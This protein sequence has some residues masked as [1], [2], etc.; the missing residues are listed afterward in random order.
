[1]IE[2]RLYPAAALHGRVAHE[3]GRQIV[4]GAIA[5]GT[6]LPREAELA[7][8]YGVSR[9]AVREGLKVLAA[10]GLVVSRRRAGTRVTPRQAWNLLDPDVLA[11]H[12]P[13]AI[14]A[15]FLK[16]LV[17]LRRLIEPAAASLAA[18]RGDRDKIATLAAVLERMRTAVAAEDG[19]TY[20]TVDAEFHFAIFRASGNM[21]IERLSS[22][23]G[24]LYDA[25]FRVQMQSGPPFTPGLAIHVAVYDAIVAGDG[26][27]A[28]Q[29]MEHILDRASNE[30]A[31]LNRR[32]P[33]AG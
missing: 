10:K 8:R 4:S 13:D 27:R 18:E 11:W 22:I 29:A 9:Q 1:L 20:R 14:N 3:I 28:R 26:P 25:T 24:P 21:L 7:K 32:N 17:E 16:D 6:N 19:D 2:K 30:I 12:P 15:A 5:E 33:S 31:A 23:L